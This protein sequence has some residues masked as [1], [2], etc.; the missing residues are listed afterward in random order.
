[1]PAKKLKDGSYYWVRRQP[2]TADN[3][4]SVYHRW[5]PMLWD[6]GRFRTRDG[7][8]AG[9]D[10]DDLAEI[11]EVIERRPR[12]TTR[13][14]WISTDINRKTRKADPLYDT[15]RNSMKSAAC[16]GTGLPIPVEVSWDNADFN[17]ANGFARSCSPKKV[18]P[19]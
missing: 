8:E 14:G 11:G 18:D 16:A 19:K 12:R 13:K 4:T 5:E 2:T 9:I 6:T 15:L 1:M 10:R 7:P 17:F 3:G